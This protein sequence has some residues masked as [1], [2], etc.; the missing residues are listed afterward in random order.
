MEGLMNKKI[1]R[2]IDAWLYKNLDPSL[3]ARKQR[4]IVTAIL[5]CLAIWFFVLVAFIIKPPQYS[6]SWSIV[7]ASVQDNSKINLPDVGQADS[8]GKSSYDAK[9]IDVRNTYSLLL[10]SENLLT[11]AALLSKEIRIKKL[12]QPIVKL[13]PMSPIIEISTSGKTRNQALKRAYAIT[14][15]LNARIEE[16]RKEEMDTQYKSIQAILNTTSAELKDAQETLL[17]FKLK[18]RTLSMSQIE[19]L[20]RLYSDNERSK[21]TLENSISRDKVKLKEMSQKLNLNPEKA[22]IIAILKSDSI[23]NN[24]M[25]LYAE[26]DGKITTL[27]ASRSTNNPYLQDAQN[28]KR[29]LISA[30]KER[31]KNL[32]NTQDIN[33]EILEKIILPNDSNSANFATDVLNTYTNVKSSEAELNSV[34]NQTVALDQKLKNYSINSSILSNLERR[35]KFA[36]AVYSNALWR[37]LAAR[38]NNNSSFPFFQIL[39]P[40]NSPAELNRPALT[41]GLAGAFL[42]NIFYIIGL[43]LLWKRERDHVTQ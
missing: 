8:E 17:A 10:K 11:H 34:S 4:Y 28:K 5:G 15:S 2:Y 24:L 39:T 25:K 31:A 36:E 22:S 23:F 42:A 7:L 18:T 35:V 38:S 26:N 40:P 21:I 37:S 32:L 33:D 14:N 29:N 27:M 43:V 3:S 16:L 41:Y 13:T 30:M 20:G 1:L 19:D 6:V 9:S 12:P